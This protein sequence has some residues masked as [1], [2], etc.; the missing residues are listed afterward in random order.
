MYPYSIAEQLRERGHDVVAVSERAGLRGAPDTE[1][2]AVALQEGRALVTDDIGFRLLES[3][4]RAHGDIHHGVVFTSNKRG[5][6]W[7]VGRLVHA[8]DRFLSGEATGLARTP[9]FTHWLR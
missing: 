9:S 2:F 5:Q 8:L 7:T 1:V 3:E 6:P 4:R